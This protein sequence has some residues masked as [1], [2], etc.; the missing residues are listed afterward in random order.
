M[1]IKTFENIDHVEVF[2]MT[3]EIR[4]KRLGGGKRGMQQ[5]ESLQEL[6]QKQA[7]IRAGSRIR[8][9]V[10]A[11]NM[12]YMWTLTYEREETDPVVVK[13][14]FKKFIMKLKYRLKDK[15]PYVAVIEIQEE[16]S[17]KAGKDILH[18]HFATNSRIDIKKVNEAW[19][20]GFVFVS[21]FS[22]ELFKIAGYLGKYIKKDIDAS[23]I[24]LKEQKR[25]L[26]SRGLLRPLRASV[27]IPESEFNNIMSTADAITE[28]EQGV[29]MKIN[30]RK[31]ERE[32]E[33]LGLN[34]ID[35][36]DKEK[37]KAN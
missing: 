27:L 34:E 18:I 19:E 35:G 25:Y 22:G 3:K 4:R 36:L 15:V 2:L 30:A 14:D 5:N 31:W 11:N 9:L 24:R 20:N 23:Q 8:E 1:S 21:E 17:E 37:G 6:Y 33:R 10:L 12:K 13:N 26:T 32:K 28:F 7:S 16:R 29:W